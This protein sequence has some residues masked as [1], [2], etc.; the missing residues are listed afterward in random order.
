[1]RTEQEKT[2]IRFG[3]RSI[4]SGASVF[5]IAEIGINHNG[6]V[7][8]A[9]KLIEAAAECGVDAVKFQSFHA[10][11]LLIPSNDRYIQ[12]MGAESAYDL[13]RRC[14][15][16][17][18]EQEKLKTHANEWGVMFLSTPFDKESVDF[19][20][21]LEVPVFKVASG[22][23]THTP[24][25]QHIATKGKPV[26]LSTG[27]SYMDEVAD[28]VRCLRQGG[29]SDILLMHCASTYP[30]SPVDMNLR[31]LETM[32]SYFGLLTGIS[33]HSRGMLFSLAAVAMGAVVIEKHFTLDRGAAGPD[34]KASLDP[35]GLKKLVRNLRRLETGLG[36]GGK[37]PAKAEAEGRKL[38]R[39]SIVAAV[40]I[41]ANEPIVPWM[42]ICKRP[43]TGLAPKYC[44]QVEGMTARRFIARDTMIQWED[45]QPTVSGSISEDYEADP[46]RI[47]FFD[48]M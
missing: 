9:A 8:E 47:S 27:M 14:E 26:F 48:P 36:T 24:L 41:N 31:A 21:Y 42:L 4:G 5:V 28:A 25:L 7:T 13:L 3:G 33:D 20:D 35:S 11:Q 6:S 39:R 34:H 15:L 12:Q 32:Q 30:V 10:D 29:V 16:S 22:D 43:G 46:D 18:A 19:L 23:I 40:D 2:E 45:L 44:G 17:F 1:M 37:R 38:G